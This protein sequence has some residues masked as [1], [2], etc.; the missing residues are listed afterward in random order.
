V[1]RLGDDGAA[2]GWVSF[3]YFVEKETGRR[4]GR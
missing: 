4:G 1:D 2:P 3:Q